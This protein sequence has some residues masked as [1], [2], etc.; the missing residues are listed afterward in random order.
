[1]GEE[2][3]AGLTRF[4]HGMLPSWEAAVLLV[5]V[6]R[7]AGRVWTTEELVAGMGFPDLTVDAARQYVTHFERCGLLRCH[8]DG[9]CEFAPQTDALRTVTDQLREA[10]DRQPVTLV[11]AV[12]S[13]TGAKL[14]SFADAFRLRRE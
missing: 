14:R 2:L 7:E 11:R 5:H 3:P 13:A 4:I 1:L 8:P 6:S 9:R 10:Y 12:Y